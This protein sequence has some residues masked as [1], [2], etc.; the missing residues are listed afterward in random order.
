MLPSDSFRKM[1]DLGHRV[2]QPPNDRTAAGMLTLYWGPGTCAIGIHLVLEELGLRYKTTKLDVHGGA[3]HTPEFL[4]INPKGKVP[5][6]VRQDG[7]V[8]TEFG[9]IATWLGLQYG[10]SRLLPRDPE[11]SARIAEVIAYIEG[12]IHG[13]GYGRI[14]RPDLFAPPAGVVTG[15]EVLQAKVV[16]QGR[17][18]VERGFA[19]IDAVLADKKQAVGDVFTIADA[20][21]FYVERWAI[22]RNIELPRHIRDHFGRT[23]SRRSAQ[24]ILQHWGEM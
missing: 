22:Q 23:Q 21:L 1:P 16:Q 4:S 14:F 24:V 6:L 19:I 12:T 2:A 5:T 11:S 9:A 18:I 10:G 3:T 8:L 15:D 7:S 13:Q 17:K 20:A